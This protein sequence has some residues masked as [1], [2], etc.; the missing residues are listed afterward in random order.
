MG[1][2]F[3]AYD[4]YEAD[5]NRGNALAAMLKVEG[6]DV[7]IIC[8]GTSHQAAFWQ[9]R[10]ERG[11]GVIVPRDATVLCV[12]ED[13]PGG[14]GNGLGTLYAWTKAAKLAE[15]KGDSE[16]ASKLASGSIS[17]ALYHTAGKGT[18]LA[19]LPGAENNNK[20]GV[21]LPATAPLGVDGA[22]VPLTILESVVKSTGIYASSRKGRLSVFWGDQVF[23]PTKSYEYDAKRAHADILCMLA[24]MPSASEW[25][26]KG[27]EKYGLVAVAKNGFDAASFHET[28]SPSTRESHDDNVT[29]RRGLP[30][31][32]GRPRDGPPD[33]EG[34]RL[35]QAGRHVFRILLAD[36]GFTLGTTHGVLVRTRQEKRPA[37]QRPA[38]VDADDVRSRRP[39]VL[40]CVHF[41]QTTRI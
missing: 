13:W 34:A 16:L 3:S 25:A 12:H 24:P 26:A 21:K 35:R 31:R 10:L 41:I 9:A 38:L 40:W 8:C 11:R 17:A 27:L 7:I 6:F 20:P 32:E 1:A 22:V 39:G 29:R 15:D 14:A 2:C 23:V 36:R 33:D 30:G 5:A 37:R 4:E 19:P 18:R 28:A